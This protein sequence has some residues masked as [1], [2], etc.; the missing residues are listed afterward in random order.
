MYDVGEQHSFSGSLFSPTNIL[1]SIEQVPQ[2]L[3]K[4]RSFHWKATQ[5]IWWEQFYNVF[6][7]VAFPLLTYTTHDI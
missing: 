7:F 3:W 5:F 4:T 2:A 6:L 1:Y